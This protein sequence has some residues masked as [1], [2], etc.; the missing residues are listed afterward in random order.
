[1]IATAEPAAACE[2]ATSEANPDWAVPV[3]WERIAE[4][5][6]GRRPTAGVLE[7]IVRRRVAQRTWGR[8]R[9]LEV[10]VDDQHVVIRGNSPTYYLKQLALA[11]VQ[12]ALPGIPVEH[13]IRV[14]S[15]EP[16]LA[17]AGNRRAGLLP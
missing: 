8:L 1:M 2:M 15:G 7:Q 3:P 13:D 16:C 12:E 17:T 14:T 6:A 9:R 5:R 10:E 11:A 4:P